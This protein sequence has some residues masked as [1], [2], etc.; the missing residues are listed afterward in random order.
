MPMCLIS[1]DRGAALNLLQPAQIRLGRAVLHSQK[2]A[3]V[4]FYRA[5][6]RTCV[7]MLEMANT[8]SYCELLL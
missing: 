4:N 3:Y 6:G 2:Q 1:P 5:Q 7:R 8:S